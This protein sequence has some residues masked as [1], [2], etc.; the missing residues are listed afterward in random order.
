MGGI[1]SVITKSGTNRFEGSAKFIAVNDQWNQV[2]STHSQVCTSGAV[3]TRCEG[4]SLA[5]TKFDHV[6]PDYAITLGGPIWKD[7]AW[8]FGAYERAETQSPQRQTV[9]PRLSQNFQ[10]KLIDKAYDVRVTGQL[11]PNMT[12]WVK[13]QDDPIDGFVIDYFNGTQIP[14]L[15][16]D[17]HEL[18]T[19]NQTGGYQA[20][21]WTGVFGTHFTAEALYSQAKNRID[22]IPFSPGPLDGGA[23]HQDQTTGFYYN[24]GAFN[25]FVSRPRKQVTVAGT[26]YMD[27]AGNSHSFKA[28]FDWQNLKSS[29]QFA[30]PNAQLFIDASINPATGVYVPFQRRDYDPAVAS[31][32]KGDIYSGYIRDKFELGKR[33]A[34][35]IGARYERQKGSSDIDLATVNASTIAPRFSGSYDVTSTGKTLVVGTY[36][37]VYQFVIQSFSDAFAQNVQRGN[38]NNYVWNGTQYVF[39]NRNSVTGSSVTRNPDVNPSYIDEGTIGFQQQIGTAFGVGIR[40]I[41]RKY[42]DLID[43]IRGFNADNS[44]FRMITNYGPAERTFKGVELTLE[45]RFSSNWN[46]LVSYTYS[47]TT[48]NNF[49]DTF[50]SLGDYTA[51]NI[52]CRTTVDPSIG[53]GGVLP[54]SEVQDGSNKLGNA[55]YDRPHALKFNGAYTKPIGPVNLTGGVVGIWRSGDTYQKSRAVNVLLPGTST[56]AG[57]T[58]TYFY[59]ERGT[60]RLPTV[61]QLDFALEATYRIVSS[62]E[63]GF[64]GEIFNVTNQEGQTTAN[65]TNWCA[66][67]TSPS[68]ACTNAVNIFGTATARGS[69][70]TPRNYRLTALV[71]F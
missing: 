46:G 47:K 16:G 64:K 70:Q 6:N 51:P 13:A 14:A 11:T 44:S 37:R 5:R 27:I 40:G 21:Q 9:D 59:D 20:A 22:V 1:I 57:P 58:A 18:T 63:L 66:N 41:Y 45:K 3:Q 48:G 54:C 56:N 69:F 36:A 26:Y 15:A 62:V 34:L 2:E 4:A 38:Y 35:E 60:E 33:V 68:V 23:P 28:G 55:S 67:T 8:F 29:S 43:D 30:F 49:S 17:L 39:S 50:S 65:N 24:G 19:Q 12:L 71:R 53:T 10:Q 31:T 42:G 32:S 7:H 25:G 52:N 61:F